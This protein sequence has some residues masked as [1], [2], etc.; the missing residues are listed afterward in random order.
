MLGQ[1]EV[2]TLRARV[3][4]KW[5]GNNI[6]F[7][8]YTASKQ[9][10]SPFR[11]SLND[12]LTEDILPLPVLARARRKCPHFGRAWTINLQKIILPFTVLVPAGMDDKL[13]EQT[14]SLFQF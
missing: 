8:G 6:P 14:Y 9:E 11:V 13:T 4:D 2:Y 10:L 1:A 3:E 7:S 5:Q 12:K